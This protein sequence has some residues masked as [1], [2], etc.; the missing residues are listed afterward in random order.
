M[1]NTHNFK[2]LVLNFCNYGCVSMIV[3]SG[4]K[5]ENTGAVHT[6]HKDTAE[7]LL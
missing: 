7:T 4:F 3:K 2:I 6:Y 5:K 1:H